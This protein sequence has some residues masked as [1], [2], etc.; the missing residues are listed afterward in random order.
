MQPSL[1]KLTVV[2][3]WIL[4]PNQIPLPLGVIALVLWNRWVQRDNRLLMPLFRSVERDYR[5]NRK[6]SLSGA[7][8]GAIFTFRGPVFSIPDP[9]VCVVITTIVRLFRQAPSSS[10]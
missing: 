10:S 9:A 3:Q 6:H 8:D 4:T 5:M 1:G 7:R 2:S